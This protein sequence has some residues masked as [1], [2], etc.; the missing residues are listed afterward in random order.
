M[1]IKDLSNID[2]A[3][4]KR[5]SCVTRNQISEVRFKAIK[6]VID[7]AY[8]DLLQMEEMGCI[9]IIIWIIQCIQE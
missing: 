8:Y 2:S 5:Q 4:R 6:D 3:N 7:N 9:D 1:I